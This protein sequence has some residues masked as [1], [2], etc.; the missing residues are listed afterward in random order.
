MELK[1]FKDQIIAIS[2]ANGNA[3]MGVA[4]DMFLNNIKD[5]GATEDQYHYA[6]ADQV[7]YAALKP[8]LK[9]LTEDKLNFLEA[10]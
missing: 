10:Y 4:T 7:D 9:E 6:G 2:A 1:N 5:A 3:D 8:H